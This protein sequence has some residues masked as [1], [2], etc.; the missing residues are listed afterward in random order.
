LTRPDSS[1]TPAGPKPVP[2][3]T[4]RKIRAVYRQGAL[5]PDKPLDL[6]EDA[7]VEIT[8]RTI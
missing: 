7:E 4:T 1:E 3:Q 5:H 6:P 2:A 8:I